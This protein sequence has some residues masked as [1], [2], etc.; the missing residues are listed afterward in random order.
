MSS[1]IL[2]ASLHLYSRFFTF[3]PTSDL[4]ELIIVLFIHKK[5]H[6]IIII[7]TKQKQKKKLTNVPC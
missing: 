1:I 7:I 4:L 6:I 5:T 3:L 2:A